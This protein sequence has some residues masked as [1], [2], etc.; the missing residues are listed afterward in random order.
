LMSVF[1]FGSGGCPGASRHVGA[2][3]AVRVRPD[4]SGLGMYIDEC[5]FSFFGAAVAVRVRRHPRLLIFSRGVSMNVL[6]FF[7]GSGGCPGAQ[8]S[9]PAGGVSM[10]VLFLFFW[11]SGGCPGAQASPPAVFCLGVPDVSVSLYTI[12]FLF[13]QAGTPAYPDGV[14]A[15]FSRRGRLRTRTALLFLF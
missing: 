7:G 15:L 10:S 14:V 4:M 13:Q 5:Y 12:L 11:G 9:P 8:A 3:G 1:L 6:F 2:G